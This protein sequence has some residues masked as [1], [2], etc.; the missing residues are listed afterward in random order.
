MTTSEWFMKL[1]REE[2]KT[3]LDEMHVARRRLESGNNRKR[4]GLWVE[5]LRRMDDD[6]SAAKVTDSD[7]METMRG[8]KES[9]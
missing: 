5:F 7:G 9:A 1:S 3:V 2:R 4:E 8:T 6:H